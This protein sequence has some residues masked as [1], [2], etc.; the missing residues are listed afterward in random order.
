MTGDVTI[1]SV[2]QTYVGY[3]A[4]GPWDDPVHVERVTVNG[5]YICGDFEVEV[6]DIHIHE[7]ALRLNILDGG[8]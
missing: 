3:L 8:I 4:R 5:Q 1:V 7:D 2:E 6:H